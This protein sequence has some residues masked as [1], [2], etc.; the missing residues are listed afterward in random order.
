VFVARSLGAEV[1]GVDVSAWKVEQIQG[2]FAIPAVAIPGNP[3]EALEEVRG[4]SDAEFD[5]IVDCTGDPRGLE[6]AVKLAKKGGRIVEVGS[7]VP[8]SVS[9]INPSDIC[10]K[11]LEIVG[12]LMA[13]AL[14]YNK[15]VRLIRANRHY[16][17]SR[18]TTH[19]VPLGR[20]NDV[21]EIFATDRYI[22]IHIEPVL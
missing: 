14:S 1:L 11:E 5:L 3:G 17:L 16:D 12:S 4:C 19:H 13:P 7:F 10:R 20:I 18:L 2:I 8:G 6:L 15:V 9:R 21:L 22:K